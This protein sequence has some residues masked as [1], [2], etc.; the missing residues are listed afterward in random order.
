MTRTALAI[1]AVLIGTGH[2][3]AEEIRYF[4]AEDAKVALTGSEA[5]VT[6][7]RQESRRFDVE[8]SDDTM[9]VKG[10]YPGIYRCTT[11]EEGKSKMTYCRSADRKVIFAIDASSLRFSLARLSTEDTAAPF[12]SAGKCVD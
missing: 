5:S 7:A 1:A 11:A 3:L 9:F 8:I 6:A 10:G 2:P 4:C 12:V